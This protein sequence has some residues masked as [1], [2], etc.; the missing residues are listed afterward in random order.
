[1]DSK[2]FGNGFDFDD[3]HVIDQKVDAISYVKRNTR[4]LHRK[5]DLDLDVEASCPQLVGKA[6]LVCILEQPWT[7]RGMNLHSRID[8]HARAAIQCLLIHSR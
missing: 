4:V 6:H 7:Q 2:D 5:R 3:D 1:M 8:Y